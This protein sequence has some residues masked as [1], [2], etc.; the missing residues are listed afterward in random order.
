MFATSVHLEPLPPGWDQLR[1][2]T[3]ILKNIH[4]EQGGAQTT[5]P[6]GRVFQTLDVGPAAIMNIDG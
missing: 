1:P 3:D 6:P 2:V 5:M 4:V